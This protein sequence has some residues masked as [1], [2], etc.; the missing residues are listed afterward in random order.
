MYSLKLET[1]AILAI[2][3]PE[4]KISLRRAIDD[5]REKK[6]LQIQPIDYVKNQIR[7]NT[8][9]QSKKRGYNDVK[10]KKVDQVIYQF[11]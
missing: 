7:Y 8:L 9:R 3:Y 11:K 5:A 1:L 10:I 4:L 6:F 2:D